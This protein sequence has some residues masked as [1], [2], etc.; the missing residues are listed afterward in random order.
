MSYSINKTEARLLARADLTIFNETQALMKQVITDAGNGLYETTV[1]DGTTMTESTPTI[2]ITGSVA[3]PT[4]TPGDAVILGGQTILLGG[5]GSNLN[6]VIADINDYQGLPGLVASKNAANNLVINYTAPAATTWTFVVGAGTGTANADLGLTAATT[7]A[8]NPTSVD[9][10]NCWQGNANSR[11][12]T[13]QMTQVILYFQQLGYTIER[14]KNT[15][16]GK[17]LK[18]VISY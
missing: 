15:N 5:T 10:Y 8:T 11:E 3:N 1:D 17:T 4:I 14:L 13:D 6:S 9:Y 2:T 7:T 16:T 12:K 18:W